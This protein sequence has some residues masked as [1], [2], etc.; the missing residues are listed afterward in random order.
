[1]SSILKTCKDK[2]QERLN[3]LKSK[4]DSA[5][6]Q[7]IPYNDNICVYVTGSLGRLEIPDMANKPDLDLFFIKMENSII[8]DRSNL[9]N[10]DKYCFFAKLH[11]IISCLEYER[12]SKNG[13]YWDFISKKNLLDIGSR[14]EDYNNSFT[15]RMLLIL[16]SKPIYIVLMRFLA[17]N[18]KSIQQTAK[19]IGVN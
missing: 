6:P 18:L 8:D 2:S 12:P 16:E 11:Q 7:N 5:F 9:D 14:E 3:I 1:M 19:T 4:L 15:A 13:L 17:K 10:I